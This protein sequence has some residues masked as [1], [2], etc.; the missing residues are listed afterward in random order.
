MLAKTIAI[1]CSIVTVVM[2]GGGDLVVSCTKDERTNLKVGCQAA[3]E[4]LN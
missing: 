4:N 2:G 3:E 1:T